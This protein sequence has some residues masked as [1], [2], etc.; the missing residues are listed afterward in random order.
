MKFH[1]YVPEF[2]GVVTGQSSVYG[3]PNSRDRQLCNSSV[4]DPFSIRG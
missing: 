2:H 4:V 1:H 3:N